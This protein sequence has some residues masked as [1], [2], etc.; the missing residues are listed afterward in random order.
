MFLGRNVYPGPNIEVFMTFPMTLKREF[1]NG[2]VI[3]A[4]ALAL[5]TGA[6]K[7]GTVSGKY[8]YPPVDGYA[9]TRTVKLSD[10]DLTLPRDVRKL[11]TRLHRAVRTVCDARNAH[12]P[13]YVE[14]VI[15]PCLKSSM[16]NA[17]ASINAPAL[18]A[19]HEMKRGVKLAR[20]AG[21]R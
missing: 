3:G 7:A 11:Y 2:W 6:A 12:A 14:A 20:Y 9:V 18:T 16:D 8:T 10:L 4:A 1:Y 15:G 21:E 13:Q 17:V 19:Y 5:V